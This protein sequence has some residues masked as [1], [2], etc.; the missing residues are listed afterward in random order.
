LGVQ[1][2]PGRDIILAGFDFGKEGT[3]ILVVKREPTG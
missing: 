1:V 2:N 3:D